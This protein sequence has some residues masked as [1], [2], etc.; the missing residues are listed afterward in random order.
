MTRKAQAFLCAVRYPQS[1]LSRPGGLYRRSET[2][3]LVE[4]PSDQLVAFASSGLEPPSVQDGDHTPPV[5]GQPLS[6]QQPNHFGDARSAY[7]PASGIKLVGE[8]KLVRRHPVL[9]HQQPAATPLL[10]RV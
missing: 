4:F 6:L 5:V 9:R 7:P 10:D 8:R 2:Q 3:P 1:S